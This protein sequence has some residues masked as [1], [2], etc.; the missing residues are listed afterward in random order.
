MHFYRAL[1]WLDRGSAAWRS[2]WGCIREHLA[3]PAQS[4]AC[5]DVIQAQKDGE[6]GPPAL[7]TLLPGACKPWQCVWL[8][9]SGPLRRSPAYKRLSQIGHSRSKPCRPSGRGGPPRRRC[10]GARRGPSRD[11]ST[12]VVTPGVYFLRHNNGGELLGFV[13]Y[14]PQVLERIACWDT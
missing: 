8:G 7:E 3:R 13:S 10:G 1:T 6:H 4:C 11:R 12:R 5:T 9:G 2:L 14:A